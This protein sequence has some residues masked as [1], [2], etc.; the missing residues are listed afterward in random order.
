VAVVANEI[1][2][3]P[4]VVVASNPSMISRAQ[5]GHVS[6]ISSA[7]PARRLPLDRP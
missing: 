4:A 1:E 6:T 5:A 2:R 3:R 7:A